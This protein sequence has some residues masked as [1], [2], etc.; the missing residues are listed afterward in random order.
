MLHLSVTIESGSGFCFGVTNAIQKAENLLDNGE[1]VYCIGQ[2]VHNDEEIK[3]LSEKGLIIITHD[4]LKNLHNSIVL[5]RAHGEPPSTYELAKQN[6]NTIIDASCPIVLKFQEKVKLAAQNNE[7]I[8]IFGKHQHPEII[9]L[10]GHSKNK[11]IIFESLTELKTLQLPKTISLYSQTTNDTEKFNEIVNY[12]IAQGVQ[13]NVKNTI[14]KSVSNR[15][16][17]LIAFAK[18]NNKIIF[19]SGKNSSNGRTS[20]Q[21]CKEANAESY[22]ISNAAEINPKWFAPYD[23][24]G[25]CGATSTPQWLMEEI[26]KQLELL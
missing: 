22:F 13:V 16:N 11:A 21:I 18:K 4:E 25:I 1:K 12:I 19:V 5:F 23:N 26:K 2:I 9:A 24:V 6:N 20:F 14:C 15:K 3:R 10:K 8:F 7:N 17:E